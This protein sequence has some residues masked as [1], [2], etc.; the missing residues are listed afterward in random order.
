MVMRET[1]EGFEGGLQIGGRRI[2]NLR[3]ADDIVLIATSAQELQTLVNHLNIVSKRY[4]LLIN[5]EKTKVMTTVNGSCDVTI[6]NQ[7]VEVMDTFPY[8]GSV[9]TSDAECT[10]DIC[11][12]L[13]KRQGIVSSLRKIWKS[14]DIT[15]DTK[16]RLLQTLVRPVTSCRCESWTLKRLHEDKLEAFEMKALR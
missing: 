13:N 11:A 9:I 16:V 15:I 2:S 5:A 1:T 8:L 10:A 14:H 3:Y 4:D 12:R 6:D 7:T